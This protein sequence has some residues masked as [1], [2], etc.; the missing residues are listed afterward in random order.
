MEGPPSLAHAPD[1]HL[2]QPW[3]PLVPLARLAVGA[4]R[5]VPTARMDVGMRDASVHMMSAVQGQLEA[6]KARCGMHG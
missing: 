4:V 6:G 2:P 1:G 3:P 5:P